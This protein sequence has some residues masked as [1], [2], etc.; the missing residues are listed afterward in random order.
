MLP[1][2]HAPVWLTKGIIAPT[3]KDVKHF[4]FRDR[5][6]FRGRDTPPL[7]SHNSACFSIS[8]SVIVKRSSIRPATVGPLFRFLD[9]NLYPS[10]TKNGTQCDAEQIYSA[11][12]YP[13]TEPA[14]Y[15]YGM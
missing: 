11:A 1:L 8:S 15:I 7:F 3:G 9:Y 5:P 2:H 12:A 10:E 13:Q 14:K 4:Y 6:S